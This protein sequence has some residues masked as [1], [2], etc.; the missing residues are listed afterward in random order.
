MILA[1]TVILQGGDG[2]VNA[3]EESNLRGIS[4]QAHGRG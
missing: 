2:A 4:L 1:G 3:V